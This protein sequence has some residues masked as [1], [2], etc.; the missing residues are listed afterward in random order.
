MMI[1]YLYEIIRDENGIPFS[2]P[3]TNPTEAYLYCNNGHKVLTIKRIL[4]SDSGERAEEPL[5]KEDL[6]DLAFEGD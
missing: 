6:F 3:F 5:S 2:R 4:I 1:G